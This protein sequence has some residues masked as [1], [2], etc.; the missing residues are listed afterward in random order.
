MSSKVAYRYALSF[1]ENAIE[2]NNLTS[3]AE[4]FKL[5][6]NTLKANSILEKTF[7]S[8]IIKPAVKVSILSEIFERRV[9]KE[10]ISFL[11]F[12]VAKNRENLIHDIVKKFLELKDEHLGILNV[13]VK[14][15][16]EFTD[17]Q[18]AQLKTKLESQFKKTVILNFKVDNTLI[19]GFVAKINDTVFDASLSHQLN[20]L[21]KQLLAGGASRN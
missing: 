12:L 15:A 13:E 8:P 17:K 14:T 2:K 16:V 10:T 6:E 11:K 9:T 7:S 4:D 21:K 3:I 19:G 20:L 5:I 1:L 18:A